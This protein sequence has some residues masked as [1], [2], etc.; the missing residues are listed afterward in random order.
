MDVIVVDVYILF[1]QYIGR[2]VKKIKR[3]VIRVIRIVH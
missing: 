3:K 1:E 2:S